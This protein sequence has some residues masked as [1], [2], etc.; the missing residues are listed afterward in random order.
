[1]VDCRIADQEW[2]QLLFRRE[3][4]KVMVGSSD[5]LFPEVV[6][7]LKD[8]KKSSGKTDWIIT[9]QELLAATEYPHAPG[10]TYSYLDPSR[11]DVK[12]I[13]VVGYDQAILRAAILVDALLDQEMGIA[14]AGFTVLQAIRRELEP[15]SN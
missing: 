10:R 14:D 1:A 12:R 13:P 8:E 11:W 7:V 6:K 5:L 15:S 9:A 4:F 3:F 2:Q